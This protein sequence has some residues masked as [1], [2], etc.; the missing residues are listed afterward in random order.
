ME[1]ES[2]KIDNLVE[3][4]DVFNVVDK[5]VISNI[6]DGCNINELVYNEVSYIYESII[7]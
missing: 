1:V 6:G 2:V 7:I 4:K 3:V 5:D